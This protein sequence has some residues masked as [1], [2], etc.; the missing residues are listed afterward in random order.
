VQSLR[1]IETPA[2]R[3]LA[4][5]FLMDEALMA[6]FSAA[7]AGIKLHHAY[8]GGLLEHVVKIIRVCDAIAPNY[9]EVDPELLRMGAFLHDLGKVQELTYGR[10][11]AYSTEG[12][13]LGHLTLGV[14]MLEAKIS[15]VELHTQEAFPAETA[16]RLKHMILSHHGSLEFGSPKVPMTLEAMV[17]HYVDTLDSKLFGAMQL[18][19][20][21]ANADTVWTAY[22]AQSGR[23]F[24]KPSLRAAQPAVPVDEVAN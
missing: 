21:D 9:P 17:L 23:K 7:P 11:L 20:D 4:E 14:S 19:N 1:S 8:H 15:E 13:M 12:Q 10:E 24:Y 5:C 6:Q 2:L 3:D 22:H 16:M 18:I